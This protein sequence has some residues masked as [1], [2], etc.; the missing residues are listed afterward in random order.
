MLFEYSKFTPVSAR[1]ELESFLIKIWR[2]RQFSYSEETLQTTDSQEEQSIPAY[3]PFLKFDGNRFRTQNFIGFIQSGDQLIEI[4]PKVFRN[5]PQVSKQTIYDHV[6]HWLSYCRRIYFPILN[7]NLDHHNV[8]TIPEILIWHFSTY[9][10]QTV[11]TLPY[12]RYQEIQETLQTPRGKID[13]KNYFK[14]GLATGQWQDIDCI[15]EP[16][17]F[18]NVLNQTIKF[19]CRSLINITGVHET[20]VKLQQ[21]LFLLDEVEDRLITSHDLDKIVLNPIFADYQPITEWCK[22]FLQQQSYLSG[23]HSETQWAMLIPMEYV[24]EDF[25]SGFFQTHYSHLFHIRTQ[26]SELYLSSEP[27]AFNLLQDLAIINKRTGEVIIIDTKYKPRWDLSPTDPK[28]G[29][30]S[31]D[32]YQMVSYAIRRRGCR[33][34]MLLYPNTKDVLANTATFNIRIESSEQNSP[35]IEITVAEVPFWSTQGI[36]TINMRLKQSFDTL[37]NLDTSIDGQRKTFQS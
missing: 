15:Y 16:F 33:K 31:N 29:V 19:V 30:S 35:H 14:N 18:D 5:D 1:D 28:Q 36:K 25:I 23:I 4:Y 7:A 13:F 24:F 9:C 37:L 11:F 8:N 21:I 34:V 22:R 17:I 32:M 26:A 3:Q 20:Q 10:H 12:S 2:E 27:R 6:F